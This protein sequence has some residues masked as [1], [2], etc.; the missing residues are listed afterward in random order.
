M[1][2]QASKEDPDEEAYACH[3]PI[4]AEDH[5]LPWSGTIDAAED[6]YTTRKESSRA[7][8]L[9]STTEI[10]HDLVLGEAPNQAPD[11]KPYQSSNVNG[12]PAIDIGQSTE[13]QK[14]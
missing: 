11:R 13:D 7:Q 2:S 3:C 5:V 6:H 1:S 10:K 14:E 4:D 12:K 8:S 9:K